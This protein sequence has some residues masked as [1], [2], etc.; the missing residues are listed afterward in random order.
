MT[1]STDEGGAYHFAKLPAGDWKVE[2]EMMGFGT[3]SR[4]LK[5]GETAPDLEI[6][7]RL[8]S[9]QAAKP[10]AAPAQ[11]PEPAEPARPKPAATPRRRP[12]AAREGRRRRNGRPDGQA[13]P[14]AA[15]NAGRNK[16][17]GPQRSEQRRHVIK[18]QRELPGDGQHGRGLQEVGAMDDVRRREDMRQ[19][20]EQCAPA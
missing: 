7:L 19:R 4:D 9:A 13:A 12:R 11:T 14:A 16:R 6:A 10:A 2:V 18:R 5:V 1:T 8:Q 3:E 17:C 15:G 20:F